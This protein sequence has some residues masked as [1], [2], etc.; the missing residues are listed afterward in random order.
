MQ[1]A[2]LAAPVRS[3]ARDSRTRSIWWHQLVL[4][5]AVLVVGFV[6]AVL[7]PR[8]L[9]TDATIPAMLAIIVLSVATLFLPWHQIP[10]RWIISVPLVDTALIG[11]LTVSYGSA[12]SFLWVFHVAWIGS[13]FSWIALV[14]C[15]VLVGAAS[16][17]RALT[18]DA[19]ASGSIALI[20]TMASLIFLGIL[21]HQ[22]SERSGGYLSLLRRQAARL[23]ASLA[24]ISRQQRRTHQLVDAI[25]VG[26]A[27]FEPG[28]EA[29]VNGT[30]SSLFGPVDEER[31][32]GAV[33]FDARDGNPLLAGTGAVE[34]AR[35]GE[36]FDDQLV[37]VRDFR[38]RWRAVTASAS[39]LSD[40]DGDGVLLVVS[41]VT[42]LLQERE[43]RERLAAVVS[44]ELRNPLT[45]IIGH[46]D[47][48]LDGDPD[49]TRPLTSR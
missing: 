11:V 17:G 27:R 48:A 18:S 10:R 26:V 28:G 30:F 34:R 32:P 16:L 1:P 33:E 25:T 15:L 24:R 35:R 21:T 4:G 41:D 45:A 14:W 39:R 37:W 8:Q 47:L 29:F 19:G 43:R 3:F 38:G 49:P 36:E 7:D 44:H 9:L 42:A 20:S 12:L 46:T 23:E 31:H 2:E 5:A 6:I 40:D 22:S 13:Y